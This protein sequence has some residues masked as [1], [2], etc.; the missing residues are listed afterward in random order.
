[1]EISGAEMDEFVFRMSKFFEVLG[2]AVRFNILLLLKEGSWTVNGLA[3]ELHR[4]QQSISRQLK[5]LRDHQLVSSKTRGCYRDYYL[6]REDLLDKA[7]EMYSL[8]TR[9]EE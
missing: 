7:V 1:M 5:V 2:N 4:T 6:K 8:L 9:S 3:E